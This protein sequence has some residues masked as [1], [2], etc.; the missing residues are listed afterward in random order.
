MRR[1]LVLAPEQHE[2]LAEGIQKSAWL[3]CRQLS[4]QGAAVTALSQRSYGAAFARAAHGYEVREHFSSGGFRPLRYLAWLWQGVTAAATARS[5][6]TD[7]LVFSLDWSFLPALLFTA[8]FTPS[9]V[10]V[11]VFSARETVGPARLV[12]KLLPSRVRFWCFSSFIADRIAGAGVAKER[13]TAERTFFT[14]ELL[15][16]AETTSQRSGVAYLSSAD[17][18]AGIETVVELAGLL[19]GEPVT[20]AV[21]TFGGREERRTEAFLA[22]LGKENLKNVRVERTLPDVAR[23]LSSQRAVVLPPRDEFS[24]MATPLVALEAAHLGC[25]VF[26]RDIPVFRE[27]FG[28]GL[29]EPFSTAADIAAQLN[30]SVPSGQRAAVA[31]LPDAAALAARLLGR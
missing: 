22:Q 13:I 21:R 7:V 5:Q 9:P 1:F 23:F 12:T 31:S 24:T 20:F 19:P 14:R 30:R 16:A 25:R 29:A 6:R 8:W 11:F 28:A 3:T 4:R 17:V 2:P 15:E 10:T 26:L 18:G 27:L